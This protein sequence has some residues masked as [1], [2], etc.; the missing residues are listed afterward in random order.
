MPRRGP[1]TVAT[2][3]VAAVVML[4][5]VLV[6][7]SAGAGDFYIPPPKGDGGN[8]SWG[9]DDGGTRYDCTNPFY[10]ASNRNGA[11][12]ASHPTCW[13]KPKEWEKNYWRGYEW[14][15]SWKWCP[16]AFEVWRFYGTRADP[17][18]AM[19]VSRANLDPCASNSEALLHENHPEDAAPGTRVGAPY[20]VS[21][22]RETGRRVASAGGPNNARWVATTNP[23]FRYG[24]TT[25][26]KALMS[27]DPAM[28]EVGRPTGEVAR[29]VAPTYWDVMMGRFGAPWSRAML[30][31]TAADSAARTVTIADD[32]RPCSSPRD[33]AV[34]VP[35]V[36]DTAALANNKGLKFSGYCLLPVSRKHDKFTYNKWK[37]GAPP[38][39]VWLPDLYI[40][41]LPQAVTGRSSAEYYSF[42]PGIP[43]GTDN[44][45][46]GVRNP[47]VIS[48][49]RAAV[50]YEVATRDA[51][52]GSPHSLVGD[53]LPPRG[54]P[55]EAENPSQ[56][57]GEAKG[58]AANAAFWR[59]RCD[60]TR[61]D[62]YE[63]G[64]PP[65]P[66]PQQSSSSSVAGV[67]V[68]VD[69][70]E[71]GQVG[72][73]NRPAT[74][75]ITQPA[76]LRCGTAPA[77]RDCTAG[78]L[79]GNRLGNVA[80]TLTLTPP[81]GGEYAVRTEYRPDN[82]GRG[83]LGLG[84]YQPTRGDQTYKVQVT[85]TAT[86]TAERR[87]ERRVSTCAPS[88]AGGLCTTETT[89]T[90]T[91]TTRQ[92]PVTVECRRNNVPTARCEFPVVSATATPTADR[93]SNGQ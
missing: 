74:T 22:S 4:A 63:P 48:R 59:A 13:T 58:N 11:L 53:P 52:V 2:A 57:P 3:L 82:T 23:P 29:N 41:P 45:P 90:V 12:Y 44:G 39:G 42:N 36:A 25:S 65:S 9:K 16:H 69:I 1:L 43:P 47:D 6:A 80:V 21:Y 83:T 33:F 14:A 77:L 64:R 86:V 61:G 20:E 50:L 78:E 49:Y 75:I 31:V 55:A 88:A 56:P 93:Q 72:G 38:A 35:D 79:T 37:I 62:V 27:R 73:A 68:V 19:T 51:V 32:G 5:G 18:A 7:P 66:Q 85:G 10:Q 89:R 46:G 34:E 91:D 71:A 70:P 28:A 92:V 81:P 60:T 15:A 40:P 76:T 54:S 84:F 8:G 30:E 67:R 17:I 24:G 87:V 26:C